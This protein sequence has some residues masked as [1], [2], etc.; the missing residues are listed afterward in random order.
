MNKSNTF[1]WIHFFSIGTIFLAFILIVRLY[2][3]QVMHGEEYKK[4][5]ERQHNSNVQDENF[6]R[7]LI[8]FKYKDGRDFFASSNQTGYILGV[9]PSKIENIEDAYSKISQ[10]LSLDKENFIFNATRE[11]VVR[12]DILPRISEEEGDKIKELKIPGVLLI[13][14]RW[15]SN[16]GNQLAAHV[17]GFLAEKDIVAQLEKMGVK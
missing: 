3:V 13:S 12:R 2:Q 1:T 6:D 14:H 11:G 8:I 16:P 5:L 9:D 7:G 10:I 15:R 17:L 4:D